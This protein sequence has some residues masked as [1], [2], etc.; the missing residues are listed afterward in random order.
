MQTFTTERMNALTAEAQTANRK[1]KNLNIHKSDDFCCHRLFN[2]VEPGSYI[3]PHRHLDPNKD[4]TFV[5]A[6]GALAVVLFD[7]NG[8]ILDS[9]VLT[10][11]GP[12]I[13]VDIPNGSFHTAISLASGTVFFEAKAGP[14]LPL[15]SD[16][17]AM[18]A[19]AEDAQ[20]APA[21]LARLTASL[22]E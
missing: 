1:R 19:P 10:L 11:G 5:I 8:A 14:Y 20:D 7:E 6:R 17:I 4:E 3:R 2:A 18:W 15:T 9:T 16:E 22:L 21:F 12:S 13:A